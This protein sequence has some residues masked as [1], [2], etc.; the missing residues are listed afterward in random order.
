MGPCES[1]AQ[2]MIE[3]AR[4]KE[5]MT[6]LFKIGNHE[7]RNDNIVHNSVEDYRA[8]SLLRHSCLLSHIN[9]FL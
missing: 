7:V 3:Q 8:P 5:E 1:Q 4:L 2:A 6:Y 9:A